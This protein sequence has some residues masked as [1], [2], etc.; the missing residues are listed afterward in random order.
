MEVN[1]KINEK[2]VRNRIKKLN[3]T[4]ADF[5]RYIGISRQLLNYYITKGCSF[6]SVERLSQ[7][8]ELQPKDI[9]IND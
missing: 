8:L 3:M 7:A 6:Q 5:A 2:K 1:M 9:I 4:M